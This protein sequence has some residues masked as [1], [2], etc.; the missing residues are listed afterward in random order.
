MKHPFL[1][2]KKGKLVLT[3]HYRLQQISKYALDFDMDN[4]ITINNRH[5]IRYKI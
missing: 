3:L 2:N 5:I 4:Y 1:I